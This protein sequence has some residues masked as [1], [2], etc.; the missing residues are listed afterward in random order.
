M[1]SITSHVLHLRLNFFATKKFQRDGV[2]I[3]R[4]ANI[5]GRDS[6]KNEP[7]IIIMILVHIRMEHSEKTSATWNCVNTREGV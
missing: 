3:A 7:L 1:Y 5:V 2:K 6:S 4:S